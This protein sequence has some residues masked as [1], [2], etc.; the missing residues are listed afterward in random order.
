MPVLQTTS[1]TSPPTNAFGLIQYLQQRLPGYDTSEYLRE[2]N[3][4]YVHVWEE[5]SKLR[6]NYFTNIVTVTVTKAQ[7]QYD[8]MFNAD[9]GLSV[10]ISQRLYQITR[11]RV[12]PSTGGLYSSSRAMAPNDPDFIA[13]ASNPTAT[14][15]QTGPYLWY[16]T[17]RNNV[18]WAQPLA[19]GTQLEVTYTFWPIALVATNIGTISSSGV[20]VTGNGTFFTQLLQPDFQGSLPAVYGQEEILAEL[21][22]AAN[23]ASAN[24]QINRVKTITNDTTLTTANAISP[25][26]S[27]SNQ[28]VLATLPEIPRE[29]IRVI[30]AIA[31]RNMYSLAADD[32][33]VTEWTAI[34]ASNMQMCKD[35]LMERQGQ[36]PPTKKRFPGSIGRSRFAW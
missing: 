8:F 21:V 4:A 7:L 9:G 5:I 30:A 15:A 23:N 29:H 10:P 1:L 14:P 28:Y 17:G 24:P 2:L 34:A 32:S 12:L 26:L 31:M 35:S 22:Y 18:Q 19:V 36:N 25:A 6:I 3:S 11:I 13:R 20:T 33:R 16:Q 27:A